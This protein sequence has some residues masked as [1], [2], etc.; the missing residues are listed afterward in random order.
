MW[1]LLFT[2]N[3]CVCAFLIFIEQVYVS[4][5]QQASIYFLAFGHKQEICV[6]CP[7]ND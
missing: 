2:A 3:K 5:H 7:E 6:D 4:L 1:I